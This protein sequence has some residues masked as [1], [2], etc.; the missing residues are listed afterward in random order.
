MLL[1]AKVISWMS[2]VAVMAPAILFM[3]GHMEL[4]Q[5]KLIM[6]VST[7]TWFAAAAISMRE[8]KTAND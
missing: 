6:L 8:K 7:I 1:I 4:E 2:L 5:V 3:A